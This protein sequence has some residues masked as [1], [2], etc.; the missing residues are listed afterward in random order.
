VPGRPARRPGPGGPG[1]RP[2]LPE[3][4][5]AVEA[6]IA[7]ELIGATRLP[8]EPSAA[9]AEAAA[10]FAAGAAAAV[11]TD[12]APPGQAPGQ[13]PGWR[14]SPLGPVTLTC[15]D[16]SPAGGPRWTGAVPVDPGHPIALY[17]R[18]VTGGE[19]VGIPT[20]YAN[21]QAAMEISQRLYRAGGYGPP[22]AAGERYLTTVQL[23]HA[24]GW[25]GS[26]PFRY[27]GLPQALLPRFSAAAVIDAIDDHQI[28]TLFAVPGMLT[29]IADEIGPGGR[30]RLAS[31]RRVLYGGAPLAD[32]QLRR[33]RGV[34]GPTLCQLY[35]RY[36]AGW[37]IT[38]LTPADH[39]R[40]LAGDADVAGSCGR[41][42]P[43]VAVD[44][45]PVPG[46]PGRLEVRTRSAMTSPPFAGPD[47]WCSLG[48]TATVSPGG[49]LR[50][51]GRLDGMINTGGFHV[52]PGEVEEAIARIPAVTAALVTGEPDPRWG[53]A[54]TAYVVMS[55]PGLAATLRD[56]LRAS[57][58]TYKIPATVHVVDRLPPRPPPG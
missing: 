45:H 5:A 23:M 19:L 25:V 58:A 6:F 56:Q 52:Y 40:L 48:D 15:R 27:L 57:L 20:S 50:L 41:P 34:F 17:P 9:P 14:P 32:G 2:V 4:P 53:E 33:L 35:G 7:V 18:A 38:V 22:L 29:R 55:D 30:P 39:E 28:T 21:W 54:V 13:D 43:G 31:L 42:V 1:D 46:R 8:V 3:Q 26:F 16:E 49:Y 47:G 36:E 51:S 37:P 44:L 24:T 10:I 12:Q 11:L